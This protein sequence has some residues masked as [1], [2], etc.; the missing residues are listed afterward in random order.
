M[1]AVISILENMSKKLQQADLSADVALYLITRTKARI[2]EMRC[3]KEFQ[4]LW[5]KTAN[6]PDMKHVVPRK[7]ISTAV[8]DEIVDCHL[9]SNYNRGKEDSLQSY[10]ALLDVCCQKID[11][12]FNQTDLKIL[13][14]IET[15]II[16]AANNDTSIG[17]TYIDQLCSH[18]TF[19]S[20]SDLLE[21]LNGL[22]TLIRMHNSQSSVAIKT[23][24]KVATICDVLNGSLPA[25]K[26]SPQLHTLLKFYLTVPLTSTTAERTFSAMRRLKNW[27]RANS[28][29]NH[30]NNIMFVNLHQAIMDSVLCELIAQHSISLN[31]DRLRFFGT[32]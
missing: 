26:C 29:P 18:C 3:E 28:G 20:R 19:I 8:V 9:P 6:I 5:D 10:Y 30:L 16:R 21:E 15:T 2:G 11:V 4:A 17:S 31:D 22:H 12:R 1:Y 7:R 32:E 25:K 27:T 24:T 23:V 14:D 13:R